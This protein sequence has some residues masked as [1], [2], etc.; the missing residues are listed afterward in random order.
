MDYKELVSELTER[1]RDVLRLF[2]EG[3][4]YQTI[5]DELVIA[6]PTVKAHMGNI[7]QRLNL[8]HLP[9]AKRKMVLV[10]R[11]CPLLRDEDLPPAPPEE[12]GEPDP[13]PEPIMEMVEEDE[14]AIVPWKPPQLPVRA[15][16]ARPITI[17]EPPTIRRRIR[18][19]WLLIGA[20]LGALLVSGIGYMVGLFQPPDRPSQ[21]AEP[22]IIREIIHE[23]T[24]QVV[25][26]AM[27]TQPA[28]SPVVEIQEVILEVTNT[29]GPPQ[30][31][32]TPIVQTMEVTRE[33][34]KI[35]VVTVTPLPTPT[36][37]PG[38][39]ITPS[40]TTTPS[41]TATPAPLEEGETWTQDDTRLQLEEVIYSVGGD[42]ECISFRF[43][44]YNDA[45][46]TTIIN[47]SDQNYTLVDNLGRRW[48][49]WKFGSCSYGCGYDRS[50]EMSGTA[51]PR[52]KYYP[53]GGCGSHWY[54]SFGGLLT[55]ERVN[56][57]IVTADGFAQITNAKWR[58]PIYH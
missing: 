43:K 21:V 47:M 5:G 51:D 2:C 35:V 18:L 4:K 29:P 37:T 13:V 56:E 10:E 40:P 58:I 53:R 6:V 20:L 46:H 41:P 39:S 26:I 31:T 17:L 38:P 25:T 50:N 54:V 55:D 19:T 11:Y 15:V 30:P 22:S 57:I 52:D 27:P 48:E 7:Y 49:F 42:Q 16:E 36:N 28:P 12:K 34:E 23:V 33:V 32:A 24:V 14:W 9:T 45:N 3:M 1:Q 44:L 8:D